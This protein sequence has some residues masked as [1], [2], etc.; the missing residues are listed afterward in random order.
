LIAGALF[1]A[2]SALDFLSPISLAGNLQ[3]LLARR[4]KPLQVGK[5]NPQFKWHQ[6]RGEHR[7]YAAHA[8]R[9][10]TPHSK[11]KCSGRTN[12]AMETQHGVAQSAISV[13]E[14][15]VLTQ[16]QPLFPFFTT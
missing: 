6:S 9:Q 12:T 11:H 4:K 13:K 7:H 1:A 2:R 10:L 8:H 16:K 3:A 14:S 15:A 5:S